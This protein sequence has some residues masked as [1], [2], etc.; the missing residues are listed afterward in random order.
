VTR[1]RLAKNQD[2]RLRSGHPWVFSNEIEAAE[3]NPGP[4]DEVL[5]EDHRG[6]PVGV[7]L[8]NPNS[9]IAVRLYSRRVRAVDEALFRDRIARAIALRRRIL[10]VERTYRLIHGEGDFLP[11]LVVDRYDDYL[12]VQSLTAG[13]ERRLE[14]ILPLLEEM[15]KAKGIICRRDASGRALEGLDRLDSIEWGHVP[16]RVDAPY[17]GFVLTVDL[18]GGQKTGEFLDQRENRLRVAREAHRRRVLD[19]YCHTGLFALHC[20]TAGAKSVLAIDSSG[21]ALER[22]R[23]NHRRNAMLRDVEFREAQVEDALRALGKEGERFDMIVLDPP[24]LVKS[25]KSMAEGLRKYAAVN[26]SAMR[27]LPSG[28]TLATATC[29]HHVDAAAFLDVLRLAAKMAGARFRVVEVM[30]Q[31]RDHPVLL[32]ARE[33]AYLTMVLAERIDGAEPGA[34]AANGGDEG[35]TG[36]PDESEGTAT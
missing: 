17:E 2:R 9:L 35:D 23:E 5:V 20:A 12:G 13:V 7:G 34:S 3:G 24:A 22:A 19:L 31:G 21:P 32:S 1:V 15:L 6:T 33:T 4:G 8:Y 10:P 30:G 27:L 16:E 26:A 11:G 28:G 29:S 14:M 36:S 25:K 18:R